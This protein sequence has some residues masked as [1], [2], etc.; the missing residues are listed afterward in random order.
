M[1]WRIGKGL[2][3]WLACLSLPAGAQSPE[4]WLRRAELWVDLEAPER[5]R[6]ALARMRPVTARQRFDWLMLRDR[7][8]LLTNERRPELLDQAEKLAGSDATR[9]FQLRLRRFTLLPDPSESGRVEWQR[10]SQ[11]WAAKPLTELACEYFLTQARH[12]RNLEEPRA[13]QNALEAARAG[14]HS[15]AEKLRIERALFSY[16]LNLDQYEEAER[17]LT[18]YTREAGRQGVAS[19]LRLQI[20]LASR[21]DRRNLARSLA[22]NVADLEAE[23]GE[24][25][26]ELDALLVSLNAEAES[27][28]VAAR[29]LKILR[30]RPAN[31]RKFIHLLHLGRFA[32]RNQ[33]W[34]EALT[35]WPKL[36][37]WE[38]RQYFQSMIFYLRQDGMTEQALEVCNHTLDR[39]PN[40][41]V[42]LVAKG[43]LLQAQGQ[44]EGALACYQKS[45]SDDGRLGEREASRA[46]SALVGLLHELHRDQELL[47]VCRDILEHQSSPRSRSILL[48]SGLLGSWRGDSLAEQQFRL[49]CWQELRRQIP[50]LTLDAQLDFLQDLT[51]HPPP[52]V[53]LAPV[54]ERGLQLSQQEM[55]RWRAQEN[56]NR[57]ARSCRARAN[58]LKGASRKAEALECL[59][60]A[61]RQLSGHPHTQGSLLLLEQLMWMQEGA[62]S[63]ATALRL[64]PELRDADRRCE[65]W[66]HLAGLRQQTNPEG[67]LQA[68]AE[69][70]KVAPDQ[71][72]RWRILTFQATLLEEQQRWS[73]VIQLLLPLKMEGPEATH[74]SNLL[75]RA[76]QKSGQLDKA[77]AVLREAMQQSQGKSWAD[78]VQ[79]RLEL[80]DLLREQ[81]SSEAD[82][83]LKQGYENELGQVLGDSRWRLIRYYV[84]MLLDQ[85]RKD[86]ALA[87]LD[88]QHFPAESIQNLRAR[89]ELTEWLAAQTNGP[90][91]PA[92]AAD[93]YETLLKIRSLRHDLDSHPFFQADRLEILQRR[94]GPRQLLLAF[95][96]AGQEMLIL[97]VDQ[98][99]TYVHQFRLEGEW[100]A[101]EL[102]QIATS[103][104]ARDYVSSR[105][106]TPIQGWL[107]EKDVMLVPL[108]EGWYVPWEL[109]GTEPL[110]TS[111]LCTR[112]SSADLLH[113]AAGDW[114]PFQLTDSLALGAPPEAGLEGAQRE[115]EQLARRLPQCRLASGPAARLEALNPPTSLTHLASHSVIVGD[116]PDSS[117]L[118]LA[119]SKLSLRQIYALKL[120]PHSLVV[121]SSCS[122][123]RGQ[124]HPQSEPLSL[125]QAFAAAGSQTQISALWP[126]DDDST[127][128][129][130]KIFYEH[131]SQGQSPARCLLEAR[132]GLA[133]KG[134]GPRDWAAFVLQ[135][136]PD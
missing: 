88:Q 52:G 17:G 120:K 111:S 28:P 56:W 127:E 55:V 78:R 98:Q 85:G 103:A 11:Q 13:E 129:F 69:A 59:L 106:I 132:R 37:A 113:L 26:N 9:Q 77:V 87:E 63:E 32:E 34:R 100:F 133:A 48:R 8:N 18:A 112:L 83:L 101:R 1:A 131:L 25:E 54:L 118:Q 29:L 89:P 49:W 70:L 44:T 72:T 46:A 58:L 117:F 19:A 128:A 36:G 96:P 51:Y 2:W 39:E 105:T 50:E 35:L 115:L 6:I 75:S 92:A 95:C 3:L 74:R 5:A 121:L 86:E 62:A 12:F 79:L 27:A 123:A 110:G 80:V 7:L 15:Q 68:Y 134:Y 47:P 102:S 76:Y 10:L 14:A 60:E 21:R 125:A 33:T 73:E 104:E 66:I 81:K 41:P 108:A 93:F 64:L 122:S 124:N 84:R 31:G 16:H 65:I 38:Q 53:R 57:Y 97:G 119:Q 130:F 82:E 43:E 61:D 23:A 91:A 67:A 30:A 94:L 42:A 4:Q 90:V 126:V 136:C 135:G 45:L 99:R 24:I 20:F 40:W 107:R 22:L 116:D 71:S 114:Q 109:L